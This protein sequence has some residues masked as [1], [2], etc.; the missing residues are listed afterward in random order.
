MVKRVL[1]L[2]LMDVVDTF[3][4]NWASEKVLVGVLVRS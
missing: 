1:F 4:R 2:Y 3:F